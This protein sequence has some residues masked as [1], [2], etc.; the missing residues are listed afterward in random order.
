MYLLRIHALRT[1]W[2]Q[3]WCSEKV[4][5]KNSGHHKQ[6]HRN[7]DTALNWV[8]KNSI[9]KPMCTQYQIAAPHLKSLHNWF[10]THTPYVCPSWYWRL[11]FVNH[12][13]QQAMLPYSTYQWI[14]SGHKYFP[15]TSHILNWVQLYT[16]VIRAYHLINCTSYKMYEKSH[17][18][19]TI[20][21]ITEVWNTYQPAVIV[22]QLANWKYTISLRNDWILYK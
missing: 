14:S 16:L 3:K 12:T 19:M 20:C 18:S 10:Q 9:W 6:Y 1:Y 2:L 4:T 22:F 15:N 11:L 21:Q 17:P 7:E 8:C 5:S 13:R